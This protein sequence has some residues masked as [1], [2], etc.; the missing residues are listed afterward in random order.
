MS[1]LRR[2]L[3][4][5]LVV[6]LPLGVTVLVIR[7]LVGIMDKSLLVLPARYHPDNLLGFHIPG[8]GVVLAVLIVLL[9]GVVVA[10][11]FGRRLV[12][13]WESLLARIPLVRSIYASVKQVVETVF[14]KGDAFRKVLLIEYP[15]RD[16]WTI[17]FLTGGSVPEVQAK[18]R[19]EVVNVFVPTTPNPTSGFFMMIPKEDVTELDMTVEE[20]L[21]LIMS[22]GVVGPLDKARLVAGEDAAALAK[23]QPKP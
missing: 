11:F 20:G 19:R 2:Y 18:T 4:A 21:K 7:L 22:L 5:G 14:S 1:R 17:A 9:T 3:I 15:R 13:A 16:L 12:A 23:K 8:L 6:W 10:N